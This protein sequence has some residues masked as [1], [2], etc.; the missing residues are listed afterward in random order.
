[1]PAQASEY[2]LAG[3]ALP[4]DVSTFSMAIDCPCSIECLKTF[5]KAKNKYAPVYVGEAPQLFSFF[6]LFT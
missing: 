2:S 3:V 4:P 1:M 6:Q 5:T